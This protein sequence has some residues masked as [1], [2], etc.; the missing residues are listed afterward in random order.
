MDMY[1]YAIDIIAKTDSALHA[2][3]HFIVKRIKSSASLRG[4]TPN[5]CYL[6][7]H[8]YAF[9]LFYMVIYKR[10]C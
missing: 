3:G 6:I 7:L 5:N 2:Y 8:I 4:S 10:I 1:F 9:H